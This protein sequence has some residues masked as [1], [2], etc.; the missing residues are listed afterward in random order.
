M[1]DEHKSPYVIITNNLQWNNVIIGLIN[2]YFTKFC[3]PNLF[4]EWTL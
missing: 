4:M 2:T 1:D 3:L